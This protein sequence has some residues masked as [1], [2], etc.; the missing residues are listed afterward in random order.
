MSEDSN[1]S[2]PGRQEGSE[3]EW[4]EQKEMGMG[5]DSEAVKISSH[6]VDVMYAIEDTPPLPLCV[7]LGFQHYLTAFGTTLSVPLILSGP[8]CMAGDNVGL[9]ELIGTIFFVGGISTL[10]QTTFGIRLPIIQG[11]TFAFLAPTF[12]ILSLPKW[13]CPA[14]LTVSVGS[15]LTA[16]ATNADAVAAFSAAADA[17]DV[18]TNASAALDVFHLTVELLAI[19]ENGTTHFGEVGGERHRQLWHARLCEIQGAV[20]L[21]SLTQVVLGF[22]GTFSLVLR[23]VGPLVIAPT[24]TLV[25]LALFDAASGKASSLWWM[26]LLTLAL[27]VIFSQCI[28]NVQVPLPKLSISCRPRL[29]CGLST[30]RLP[31]FGLFPV[32]LAMVIS[33]VLCLVLTVSGALPSDPAA[34]G[35]SARTD[36]RA[37]ALKDS[38]WIRVPYPGQWGVPTVSAG[39]V[40]GMVAGVLASMLESVGDYYAC[41]RLSGAPPPPS[42][43]INRAIGVEGIGCVLAGAF[44]SGNGTTSYS[45]NVAAIGVT[46]VASRR[47]V[48]TAGVLLLVLGCLG[49]VG[50]FFVSIPDPVV[51]GMFLGMFA[52]ITAVGLSNLRHVDLRR[53]RNMCVL[54]LALFLGLAVPRW[55]S[56]NKGAIDTGVSGLDQI[57]EVLLSTSMLVGGL[58]GFI[59]DNLLPGTDEERGLITWNQ[60]SEL[61][62]HGGAVTG[63]KG[64]G[65]LDAAATYTFPLF[66]MCVD[67][68]P[69]F[70]R[71]PFCPPPRKRRGPGP[72]AEN[73]RQGAGEPQQT[74][75][76]PPREASSSLEG[77]NKNGATN[78]GSS[79][80]D[81]DFAGHVEDTSM[82]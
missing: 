65:P 36:I 52:M 58:T 67:C 9:S 30:M 77:A 41:A 61:T 74:L 34:W 14:R 70:G 13:Q 71:L 25:G 73:G 49:K 23:Y 79:F 33:W 76:P 62:G 59:L 18:G 6:A 11:A 43:A 82:V 38:S 27:I 47:V 63:E 44:G 31:L 2:S 24:V 66:Q 78:A 32:L 5:P 19:V 72:D 12:S 4:K 80:H 20:M 3:E 81:K 54:G 40:L 10:L 75:L 68:L 7:L 26:A 69:L 51:G 37:S 46:K 8:L 29:S 35:Y 57:I 53:P 56:A 50:A 28:H 21:A 60:E 42:H 15:N 16:N 17:E 48:Q 39:S 1:P 22:T 64:S 45:E 55:V